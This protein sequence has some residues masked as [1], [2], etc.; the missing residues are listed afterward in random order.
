MVEPN[1]STEAY[2]GIAGRDDGPGSNS[3]PFRTI[4]RALDWLADLRA[5]ADRAGA[6]GGLTI[7]LLPG[8][9]RV[10]GSLMFGPEHAGAAGSPTILRGLGEAVI[11]GAAECRPTAPTD[12]ICRR[13]PFLSAF[14]ISEGGPQLDVGEFG[15]SRAIAPAPPFVL[16]GSSLLRGA[17][18][19]E[20]GW[21]TADQ[22]R[23]PEDGGTLELTL[24]AETFRQIEGEPALW[25]EFV[26]TADWD[27]HIARVRSVD[28]ETRRIVLALPHQTAPAGGFATRFAFQNL[29]TGLLR[30]GTTWL[31]PANAEIVVH[32]PSAGEIELCPMP[33]HLV[34]LHDTRH[35]VLD[36]L[37]FRGGLANAIHGVGCEDVSVIRCHAEGFAAGG[38]HIGGQRIAILDSVVKDVGT[39]PLRID[40]GQSDTLVGGDS[41]VRGCTFAR[42]G[43]RK[44]IY[45]P[46]VKL[47]GVG[48]V[49]RDCA[50]SDAPHL[51]IEISGNDHLVEGCTF[52][53][54]VTEIDDMGAIY[55]N[56]GEN[57]LERGHRIRWN[58][59][60]DI[61]SERSIASAVYLDRASSGISVSENVFHR[62]TSECGSSV[63][64]IHINGGR[65]IDVSGNLFLDCDC[66][67]ELDFYLNT[68]GHGDV[69]AMEAGLARAL[70][71]LGSS[72]HRVK[73]PELARLAEQ[74]L[75]HPTSNR[76]DGNVTI[77]GS[78]RARSIVV[79]GG[80]PQLIEQNDNQV[81]AQSD[82]H[83][84][85][86][87]HWAELVASANRA[88]L[89]DEIER[90]A[91]TW[92]VSAFS[93]RNES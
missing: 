8:R 87:G 53:R 72:P 85:L 90:L 36:A 37:S 23:M 28:A 56:S 31:D 50:F 81:V 47:I 43:W 15:V 71:K 4:H 92:S 55:V 89:R 29:R 14:Q 68:W 93:A 20:R 75:L 32:A 78:E 84:R 67:V 91:G 30:P 3:K 24:D 19:P 46:A 62:I 61:G 7:N 27:W 51:A 54:L 70:A 6:D 38:F 83:F 9:H 33:G 41:L 16:A 17:R 74:S 58:L 76:I 66:S 39:S 42:W 34:R 11:S 13:N 52:A 48:T 79:A 59:F 49:V 63:R 25:V 35:I 57:P 44:P 88:E 80:Q 21:L 22:V 18:L 64:A 69:P 10:E 86:S 73:Y 40:A 82:K 1:S 26:L 65:D 77:L 60:R 2:V 45:E 5:S 12:E